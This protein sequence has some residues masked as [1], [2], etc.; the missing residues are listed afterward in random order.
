M[1]RI[2]VVTAALMTFTIFLPS[3]VAWAQQS[4]SIAGTAKDTSGAVLPGVTVEAGSPALIE[5]VRTAVTDGEG[6][7][8]ITDLRPGEYTVTF[9]LAGF[10]TFRREGI[11]L[12]VGFTAQV[13]ANMQVGSLEET[14]TVTGAAPLVDTQN[15]RQQKTVSSEVLAALPTGSVSLTTLVA[16]TP[17]FAGASDVGGGSRGT[18]EG[19]QQNKTSFHGK[20]GSK[21]A[22]EGMRIQNFCSGASPAYMFNVMT[23]QEIQLETG[24]LSAESAS[25]GMTINMIAK[26]GGNRFTFSGSGLYT[27]NH[28]QFDNLTDALR[29]RGLTSRQEIKNIFD[30]GVTVAGPIKRDKLWFFFAGRTWGT[31]RQSPGIFWNKTQGTMVYTPDLTRPGQPYEWNRSPAVRVT[32]QVSPRNKVNVFT[33]IQRDFTSIG[34]G[35]VLSNAPESA[36]GWNLWPTGMLQGTWSSPLSNK[37]LFEAGAAMTL[38]HYPYFRQAGVSPDDVS[39]LEQSTNFRY[40]APTF[41]HAPLNITDRYIQRF[42]VAYVTGS[43]SFKAG[44]TNEQGIVDAS[45][46][47]QGRPEAKG[48]S[49]T[50]NRGVPISLTQTVLPFKARAVMKAETAVFAQDQWSVERLTLTM[51]VRFDYVNAYVPENHLAAGQFTA[52]RDFAAVR[53]IPEWKDLSPRIGGSYDLF[54]TGR[55]ALKVSLG[56]YLDL[57]GSTFTQANNPMNTSVSSTTRPWTDSNLNFVPDCNLAN[58]AANGECGVIAD[59]N[60]GKNNPLANRYSDE[61]L[62]GWGVRSYLWDFTTEVQHQLFSGLSMTGGW[63]HN[64]SGNYRVTDNVSV[65]PANYDAYCIAAPV[66]PRLPGGGGYQVCG[67]YDI[68]PSKFG[69]VSN[70]VAPASEFIGSTKGVTCGARSQGASD[71]TNCGTND[72]FGVSLDARLSSGIRIGGGLDAGRTIRDACFLVD[73]P[74]DLKFCHVVTRFK[75]QTQ[76]KLNGSYLLPRGFSVSGTFQNVPGAQI[77]AD[78]PATTAEIAPSLGRNLAGGTRTATAP[79]I[80]PQTQFEPRRTQIDLRL[81]KAFT[82]GAKR[83]QANLDI[84]NITNSNSV[85]GMFTTYGARWRQPTEILD[86]RLVQFGGR[87]DF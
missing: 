76:I 85:L 75:N 24:G 42:S 64:W 65:T 33:D 67:L 80:Q 7:Y 53:K 28:L 58:F 68:N 43:H 47:G 39:I 52:A 55:T 84:Y 29:A 86:G 10:S 27:N 15:V 1:P 40:N 26:E 62:R 5:K 16:L 45:R 11:V 70:L 74:Q 73:S 2:S 25:T 81:S 37:L 57:T 44:L 56:R 23:V 54:G 30:Y 59:Q 79:L 20:V 35:T 32:W 41:V 48:V 12:T 78:Y 51:G 69:Q 46:E 21:V 60:F 34:S 82:F 63:Y 14:V 4:S 83:L 77:L 9:T 87:F 8:S 71:Y 17:G 49:Y 61:V 50:F 19:Q 36:T 18:F 31:K 6:R 13:N 72:F 38:F 22:Y 3:P 66:D